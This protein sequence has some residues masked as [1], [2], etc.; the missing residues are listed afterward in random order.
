MFVL[1]V[2]VTEISFLQWVAVSTEAYA[3]KSA[4]HN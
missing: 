1:K 4:G 3:D 2:L